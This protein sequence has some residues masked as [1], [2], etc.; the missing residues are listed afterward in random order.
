MIVVVDSGFRTRSEKL[1]E[2]LVGDLHVG[3][4]TLRGGATGARTR[5]S[6]GLAEG[7]CLGDGASG[8]GGAR[9]SVVPVVSHD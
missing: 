6:R 5:S 8:A 2:Q 3:I 4:L 7:A 9:L 1:G